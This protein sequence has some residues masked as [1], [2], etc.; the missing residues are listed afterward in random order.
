MVSRVDCEKEIRGTEHKRGIT[1]AQFFLTLLHLDA[2]LSLYIR[3]ATA[4]DR[5][6]AIGATAS[7]ASKAGSYRS[8]ELCWPPP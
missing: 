4:K 8:T 6:V 2:P 5:A 1:H 3:N 7:H